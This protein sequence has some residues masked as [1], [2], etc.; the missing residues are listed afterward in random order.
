MV[1]DEMLDRV[2]CTLRSYRRYLRREESRQRKVAAL[3]EA[4][5]G[6]EAAVNQSD[7][8]LRG[9]GVL[10]ALLDRSWAMRHEQPEETVRLARLAVDV[11]RKL[12]PRWHG[13]QDASDWQARAWGEWGNALRAKDDLVEAE[14]AFGI[15]FEFFIQ[16]TGNLRL[17]A[18]LYD[19]HASYLGTRRQF[20]L[21]F[22]A[23]DISHATYMELSD[24]HL[25]GRSLLTKAIYTYYNDQPREAIEIN[26]AGMALINRDRD[27]D[28]NFFAIH[29]ELLF[30]V[31]LGRCQEARIV[32]FHHQAEFQSLGQINRLKV[33]W[34]QARISLGLMDL[35]AA[36]WILKDVKSGFE[37]LGLGFAAALAS[38]ELALVCMRQGRHEETEKMVLEVHDVFVALKIQREAFGAI[39]VLKEAFERRMGTIG[40]LEDAVDFL[41]RWYVNPN[42][43][44]MPRGE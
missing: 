13:E 21:A 32:L 24:Q 5:G 44:F 11:A 25:A 10:K 9:L 41:R 39:M 26:R 34:L 20:N 36:E 16:G 14:R 3:L 43:R 35:K 40:L 6:W 4:G 2:F 15:A 12:D 37:Q 23:L 1:D 27:P 19:Y 18:R 8:P 28:L 38:L 30:L 33:R 29:N 42:E 22:T 31:D 17:K 7:I